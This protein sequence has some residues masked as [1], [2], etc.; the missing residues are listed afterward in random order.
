MELKG[1]R[2][3]GTEQNLSIT[4]TMIKTIASLLAKRRTL[5][6]ELELDHIELSA[7]SLIVGLQLTWKNATDMPVE[8]REV[9]LNLFHQGKTGTP[10]PLAYNGRFVRIPYQKTVTKI[11]GL[12]SIQ[13]HAGNSH[14]ESLRFLTR[15][16][17]D[18]RDGTYPVELHTT[19][20]E[21]IYLHSFD[22]KVTTEL[23]NRISG[24]E[25]QASPAAT[26]SS[27]YTRALRLGLSTRATA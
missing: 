3:L 18:L 23:K 2:C 13:I 12:N 10:L 8:I 7:D 5:Q 20:E 21:G 22:L 26:V 1:L 17:L 19:V 6:V 27:A 24:S 9:S 4:P 11:A 15:E 25:S 14:I 16:I